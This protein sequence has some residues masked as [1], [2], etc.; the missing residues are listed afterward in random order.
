M[1]IKAAFQRWMWQTALFLLFLANLSGGQDTPFSVQ[2]S[3]LDLRI[4]KSAPIPAHSLS[5][6]ASENQ[7]WSVLASARLKISP[8]TGSGNGEVTIEVLNTDFEPGVY[9]ESVTFLFGEESIHIPVTLDIAPLEITRLKATQDAQY[10]MALSSPT[11][12]GKKGFLL[13]IN[14]NDG[15]IVRSREVGPNPSDF[16]EAPGLGLVYTL[17]TG[18]HPSPVV[19]VQDW[20]VVDHLTYPTQTNTIQA[21]SNGLLAVGGNEVTPYLWVINPTSGEVIYRLSSTQ[22]GRPRLRPMVFSPDGQFLYALDHDRILSKYSFADQ[23]LKK[24]GTRRYGD[25][26]DEFRG[27]LLIT[28]SGDAL[29]YQHHRTTST[30]FDTYQAPDRFQPVAIDP[31]G[32]IAIGKDEIRY[33]R[34]GEF[35]ANLDFPSVLAAIT[36]DS[37]HLVRYSEST[38]TFVSKAV[39]DFLFLPGVSPQ[40]K[41]D[42]F[43]IPQTISEPPVANAE[44]YELL[45][46]LDPEALEPV[47]TSAIPT[48]QTKDLLPCYGKVFWRIDSLRGENRTKGSPHS[49][50]IVPKPE[51]A[52]LG[53]APSEMRISE[54]QMS[55]SARTRSQQVEVWTHPVQEPLPDTLDPV[56]FLTPGSPAFL[57]HNSHHGFAG[58]E[59]YTNQR[60][61]VQRYQVSPEGYRLRNEVPNFSKEGF[62]ILSFVSSGNFFF[63]SRRNSVPQFSDIRELSIYQA[64][65]YPVLEQEFRLPPEDPYHKS[66]GGQLAAEGDLLVVSNYN[67]INREPLT[68][69]IY[70]RSP[71]GLPWQQVNRIEIDDSEAAMSTIATDGQRIAVKHWDTRNNTT[72]ISVYSTS[73]VNSFSRTWTILASEFMEG[74]VDK[75][76]LRTVDID[77]GYLAVASPET[78]SRLYHQGAI[79]MFERL[80]GGKWAKRGTLSAMRSF[81]T[82]LP[83]EPFGSDLAISNGV[84]FANGDET[85]HRFELSPDANKTPLFRSKPEKY[86]VSGRPYRERIDLVDDSQSFVIEDQQLPDWM[87]LEE[88]SDGYYLN[89]IPP[90]GPLADTGNLIHL[91][92]SDSDGAVSHLVMSLVYYEIGSPP[93]ILEGDPTPSLRVGAP[94]NLRPD[95]IGTPPLTYQWFFNGEPIIGAVSPFFTIAYT[96]LDDAGTYSLSVSDDLNEVTSEAIEVSVLP[97]NREGTQWTTTGGDPSRRSHIPVTLGTHRFAPAWSVE[98]F[99][100]GSNSPPVIAQGRIITA[101]TNSALTDRVR[102]FDL[103]SGEILWESPLPSP[104]SSLGNPTLFEDQVLM[105]TNNFG[106]EASLRAFHTATG[107]ETWSKTMRDFFTSEAAPVADFNGVWINGGSLDGLQGFTPGGDEVFLTPLPTGNR[108][109][110]VLTNG[111]IYS[112]NQNTLSVFDPVNG[113]KEWDF[114]LPKPP[115]QVSMAPPYPAIT[116]DAA[117][118]TTRPGT[119]ACVDLETRSI[120]WLVE[121]SDFPESLGLSFRGTPAIRGNT[122]YYNAGYKVAALN[123]NSGTLERI[124]DCPGY[125]WRHQPIVFNDYLVAST[126][127]ASYLFDLET[128]QLIQ[129]LPSGGPL[130]YSEGYLVSGGSYA[131]LTAFYANDIPDILTTQLPPILEGAEYAVPIIVEHFDSNEVLTFALKRGPAFLHLSTEGILTANLPDGP[132]P[133]SIKCQVEVS[134]QVN[135]P[136]TRSF[137][138]EIITNNRPPL[139]EPSSLIIQNPLTGLYEQKVT[140]ENSNQ[141][142]LNG[143]KIVAT[144]LNGQQRLHNGT[145]GTLSY[146]FAIP[147]GFSFVLNLRYEAPDPSEPL[148]PEL[149]IV[150]LIDSPL[151]PRTE[152]RSQKDQLTSLPDGRVLFLFGSI[153]GRIYRVQHSA[154][155]VTWADS[156]PSLAANDFSTS[157]ISEDTLASKSTVGF[158]RVIEENHE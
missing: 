99:P 116:A 52:T 10:V 42:L 36:A 70:R 120:R 128:T 30:L 13:K 97:A 21:S 110:P 44:F 82:S 59:F 45:L 125:L 150:E 129:T 142:P 155:L 9:R 24:E 4:P 77:Q 136:V 84:V 47:S 63:I 1:T 86:A 3:S 134:D 137:V 122:A 87:Q 54:G 112:F 131:T 157:W 117:F 19:Q 154:D 14:A 103:N 98:S 72:R 141:H 39:S 58:G 33:A 113:V 149:S 18:N 41:E 95:I 102:A 107:E 138:I 46:G 48:F 80:A 145:N 123:V 60:D 81:F 83:A 105:A 16:A 69:W 74:P 71:E 22:G 68:L 130:A 49:F 111:K 114:E 121:Y 64:Y 23:F 15:K 135:D 118:L 73:N 2:P 148:T 78:L 108:W 7:S 61:E 152:T 100:A 37:R 88:R 133:A 91:K 101:T 156:S 94:M 32:I 124:F 55:V 57:E 144:G 96:T 5:V 12:I 104:T 79:F 56:A 115:S 53:F 76:T 8:E 17:S 89:G 35:I 65:P 146:P 20:K 25:D 51:T 43:E 93:I 119:A 109:A 67:T 38:Q 139:V 132:V 140:I 11:E 158:L 62:S 151:P 75:D 127:T 66:F 26:T 143:L 126:S 153:P 29:F 85:L 147:A 6:S 40:P 27:D 28:T 34:S 106:R 31:D 90:S 92:A 50:E